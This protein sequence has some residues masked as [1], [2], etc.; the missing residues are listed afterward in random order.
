M[1]Y[2]TTTSRTNTIKE[3]YT[4]TTPNYRPRENCGKCIHSH[5]FSG[6]LDAKCGKYND[7]PIK[8][9]MVCDSFE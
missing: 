2:K 3:R 5:S 7:K 8:I 4:M 1:E 6:F 9:M